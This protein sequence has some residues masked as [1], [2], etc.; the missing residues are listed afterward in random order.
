MPIP[1]GNG[2]SVVMSNPYWELRPGNDGGMV[3]VGLPDPNGREKKALFLANFAETGNAEAARVHAGIPHS[4]LYAWLESDPDFKTEYGYR[5]RGCEGNVIG[6]LYKTATSDDVDPRAANV[7][8]I[9][10]GKR[11]FP[12]HWSEKH[13]VITTDSPAQAAIAEL[14][15]RLRARGTVIEGTAT[16]GQPA[17]P[18]GPPTPDA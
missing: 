6:K 16:V 10:W 18:P 7:A 12:E 14:L 4:T 13:M 15:A 11:H 9:V 17:L 8:A 3:A 5:L 2:Y 1:A